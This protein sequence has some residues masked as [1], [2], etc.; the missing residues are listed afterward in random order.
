MDDGMMS[1]QEAKDFNKRLEAFKIEFNPLLKKF[2]IVLLTR[3]VLTPD[4]RIASQL[5]YHCAIKFEEQ[6]QAMKENQT[7]EIRADKIIKPE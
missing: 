7:A 1:E 5:V 6:R 4:G 2:N 3:A